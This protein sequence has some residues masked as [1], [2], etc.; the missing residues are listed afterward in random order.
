MLLVYMIQ[1]VFQFQFVL[2]VIASIDGGALGD[3]AC[4]AMG[5]EEYFWKNKVAFTL[6]NKTSRLASQN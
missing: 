4:W 2:L 1:L 6:E 3:S 5:L